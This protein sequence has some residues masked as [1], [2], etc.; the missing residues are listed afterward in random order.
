MRQLKATL[1]HENIAE[2]VSKTLDDLNDHMAYWKELIGIN[3]LNLRGEH[4]VARLYVVMSKF[5]ASIMSKWSSESSVALIFRS[6]DSEF[7]KDE[8]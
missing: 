1:D 5:L 2:S 6:F 7:F 4:Y 8:I 3:E